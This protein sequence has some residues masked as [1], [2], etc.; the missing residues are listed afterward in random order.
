MSEREMAILSGGGDIVPATQF[1]DRVL[2]RIVLR[3]LRLLTSGLLILR[4]SGKTTTFGDYDTGNE[5]SA[6]VTVTDARFYSC[7]VLG[8][9]VG[10]AEAYMQGYWH[11]DNLT[12]VIRI[13]ARNRAA[14][15]GLE[16]GAAR[17]LQPVRKLL[18][19]LQ[20]NSRRGSRRNIAAHYDLGNDFFKL[21]LD[22][23]MMYSSA[24]FEHEDMNLAQAS[25]AKLERICRK[26]ELQATDHVL[27]IGTGWGG[28]AIYAAQTY[29][30]RVTTTTISRE[31]YDYARAQVLAA[32]VGDRVT[33][34]LDDYRELDGQYDKLVSIEMVEAVGDN[35]LDVFFG[36]C[37]RLL[38]AD[39]MMLLQAITMADQHYRSALQSVDFI[40]RYIFPGGF[41]PSVSR[42]LEATTASTD[43]RIFHLEDIGEHYA[44]TLRMWKK[45]F[46]ANIESVRAMGYSSEFVRMWHY[47]FCYCE[48]AFTEQVIGDV[49]MLLVKP[50]CRREP[51]VPA[52]ARTKTSPRR[53]V[54]QTAGM[55]LDKTGRGRTI[56]PYGTDRCD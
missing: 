49:Q 19:R 50:R 38:K 24:V 11:T 27:E 53:P 4:E 33:L 3:R 51:L 12:Q 21:W 18:H 9:A 46:W 23:N 41:L 34:L 48:G 54:G 29:G 39:G 40:Q 37:S 36:C 32:G 5:L 42:I 13:L 14:L 10:A 8:G 6:V 52:L 25:V 43:M 7:I 55:R 17:L 26:L 35:Y 47:Y 30:C 15:E 44:R 45:A 2:R 31:Q 28:F 1:S 56:A 16:Q 22:D 20:R